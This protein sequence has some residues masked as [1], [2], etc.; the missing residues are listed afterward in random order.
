M[1]VGI[2]NIKKMTLAVLWVL[3]LPIIAAGDDFSR[4]EPEVRNFEENDRRNPPKPGAILFTGSS[5]IE[6]W[7][8]LAVDFEPHYVLNRGFNGGG[9]SDVTYF[10][11]RIIV[12]YKPKMI[13]FY[14]GENDLVKGMS[15]ERVL[16][17]FDFFMKKLRMELPDVTTGFISIKP[18]P[19]RIRF[20]DRIR[21]SNKLIERYTTEHKL[22]RYIDV[23]TPMIDST[24]AIRKELF[25]K[26]NDVHMN[27]NGYQVWKSIIAAHL[28]NSELPFES[29]CGKHLSAIKHHGEAHHLASCVNYTPSMRRGLQLGGHVGRP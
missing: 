15:P 29:V 8:S 12:P 7:K 14:A 5:S 19:G 27:K 28:N 20:L 10:S 22:L 17:D 21:T 11:R 25:D 16:A 18:S 13:L 1:M 24:G 6:H 23:F 4:R 2:K 9:I 3:A 26:D